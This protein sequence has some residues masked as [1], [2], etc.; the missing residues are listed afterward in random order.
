MAQLV[1]E[2]EQ[3]EAVKTLERLISVPSYNGPAEDG[4][5]FGRK[6]RNALDEMMKICDE[7]GFK[8]YEDPDGYYGYAE[9]GEGDKVFGV[10]C[11]LDT[12]P[13]GDLKNWEH[14]PFKG[15]VI[16]N[17]VYG[18]GSQDDKGP[19]IA[20]LF[21]VKALMD[22]GYHFNQRIRFIYGTDEEILWRGI[23]QYNK[24]EAQIDSG[25]SPDAEF[26]LI[27]AEKGLEQAY[28]VGPGTDKL[29]ISLKNAF[30]AV[31]DKAVYDGPKQD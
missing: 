28:L 20:A 25:I 15:T 14:D 3:Q 1:N 13:A 22:A 27:Y 9:V 12:V 11:H 4:A 7:L 10:I 19:G 17:A 5:P 2:K 6:I 29:N 16:N 8:T 30:N 26:P 18:R 21:A 24:K 31:P 23:A